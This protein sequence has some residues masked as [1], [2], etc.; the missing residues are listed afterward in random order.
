VCC[1]GISNT[2]LNLCT[3]SAEDPLNRGLK[4]KYCL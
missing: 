4:A 1:H 3:E 2:P